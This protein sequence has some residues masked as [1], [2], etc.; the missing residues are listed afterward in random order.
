M[1]VLYIH[2]FFNCDHFWFHFYGKK[3][4]SG[5]KETYA[6]VEITNIAYVPV[7]IIHIK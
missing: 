4:L 7:K 6:L 3:L 5:K 2:T 1:T